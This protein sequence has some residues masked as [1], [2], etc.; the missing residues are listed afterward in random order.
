LVVIF[1]KQQIMD[2]YLGDGSAGDVAARLN[3]KH[4]T[5]VFT[6]AHVQRVWDEQWR[7]ANPMLR[8]LGRRPETGFSQNDDKIKL[9]KVFV[10]AA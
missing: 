10:G 6:A 4:G 5:N 8:S 9:A 1:G 7:K 2:A 3:E